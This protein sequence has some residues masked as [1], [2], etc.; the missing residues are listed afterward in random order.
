MEEIT[1]ILKQ[2]W[3][4]TR[5]LHVSLHYYVMNINQQKRVVLTKLMYWN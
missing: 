3:S 2:T 5:Q 4:I 1:D